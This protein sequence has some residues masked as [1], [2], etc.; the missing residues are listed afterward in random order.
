MGDKTRIDW[1][2]STIS[3]VRG[4][5]R[6]CEYCYARKMNSRWKW[7]E[8]FGV[9]QFFP[10]ALEQPYKWK[11]PRII[12]VCSLG[13]LFDPLVPDA[14]IH[15]TFAMMEDNP[16]HRFMVLTKCYEKIQE[17]FE[18]LP[19]NMWMGFSVTDSRSMVRSLTLDS[20]YNQQQF[21]SIEPL[22]GPLWPDDKPRLCLGTYLP[23]R[24]SWIIIGAQT[25]PTVQPEREWVQ[26]ILDRADAA[27]IPVLMKHNL[28][29]PAG[30]RRFEFPAE[31]EKIRSKG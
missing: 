16:Q 6:G 13:E 9:P 27:G 3:P 5:S 7:V 26:E 11:K 20:L 21:L 12:F 30:E 24:L 4:C 15:R 31:L 22:L 17:W 1:C 18:V 10:K 25:N 2:D 23:A 29:W 8:D 19:A 28:I 14:W